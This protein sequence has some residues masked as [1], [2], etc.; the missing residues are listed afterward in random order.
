MSDVPEAVRNEERLVIFENADSTIRD[1]PAEFDQV[2]NQLVESTKF[3][4]IFVI[5][6]KA[7]LDKK[8][9]RSYESQLPVPGLRGM[10]AAKFVKNHLNNVNIVLTERDRD[11][12]NLMEIDLFKHDLT[13]KELLEL[14]KTINTQGKDFKK[15]CDEF[16]KERQH[17]LTQ[18]S[19][20]GGSGARDE[21]DREMID[22]LK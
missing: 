4:F 9:P 13:I 5:D 1:N 8:K 3:R 19:S 16:L 14:V 6:N 21:C 12:Y 17:K 2:V 15:V 11:L 18:S 10:D 20:V 7:N 22:H